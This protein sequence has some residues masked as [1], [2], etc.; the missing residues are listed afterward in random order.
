ME[1]ITRDE[2]IERMSQ[3]MEELPNDDLCRL[4]SEWLGT[5]LKYHGDDLFEEK[6]VE[7]I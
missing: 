6:T 5:E 7:E 4:C 1:E 2:L 3:M